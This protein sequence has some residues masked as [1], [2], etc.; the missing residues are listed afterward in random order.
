MNFRPLFSVRTLTLVVTLVCAYFG[1]WEA[2]KRYGIEQH[3][4]D[5]S[6]APFLVFH[7]DFFFP[8]SANSV[9]ATPPRSGSGEPTFI[10][11]YSVW[12]FG[13]RIKLPFESKW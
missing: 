7:D 11:S 6:P 3:S 4:Y 2:T 13:S 8:F 10:R 12:L 5:S 1:A 9:K